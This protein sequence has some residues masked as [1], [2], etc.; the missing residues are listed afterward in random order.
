MMNNQRLQNTAGVLDGF[1]EPW[2]VRAYALATL[3]QDAGLITATDWSN[4]L[5][6]AIRKVESTGQTLTA[7]NY[8]NVWLAALERVVRHRELADATSLEHYR[9]AWDA[10]ARRTPHGTPIAL[11]ESDFPPG[12]EAPTAG[13]HGSDDS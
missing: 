6:A 11:Q 10:A 7:D 9:A 13:G 12:D 4:Q 1:D 3:L 8:Y 5:G 2:Q